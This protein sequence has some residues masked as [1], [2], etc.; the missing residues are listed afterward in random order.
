[1]KLRK[2][3]VVM[4]L[5]LISQALAQAQ[6][7]QSDMNKLIARIDQLTQ[8]ESL[9]DAIVNVSNPPVK[10]CRKAN[11]PNTEECR[12]QA[13]AMMLTIQKQYK[14]LLQENKDAQSK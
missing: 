9:L 14:I 4:L 12:T 1:M 5:A 6:L 10:A 3:F 7:S 8:K 2:L 11:W 13:L